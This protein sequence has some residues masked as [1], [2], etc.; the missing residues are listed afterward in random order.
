MINRMKTAIESA[1]CL[2]HI[3]TIRLCEILDDAVKIYGNVAIDVD[4]KFNDVPV[5]KT[6]VYLS[7][8]LN[9]SLFT[10]YS[11]YMLPLELEYLENMVSEVILLYF[12]ILEYDKM[13]ESCKSNWWEDAVEFGLTSYHQAMKHYSK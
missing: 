13:Q 2:Q 1:D 10:Y 4:I 12:A 8:V 5:D 6:I 3:D 7:S 9:I 11:E